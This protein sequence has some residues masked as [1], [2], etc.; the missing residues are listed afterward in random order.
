MNVEALY[1]CNYLA[2]Q[3]ASFGGKWFYA[4]IDSVEYVNNVTSEV[5]Y[6]IDVMQT[7]HFQYQSLDRKSVV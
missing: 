4:F 1:N 7:W 6:T 2:F 3:N 5:T